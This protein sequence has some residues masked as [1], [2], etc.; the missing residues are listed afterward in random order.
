MIFS[1]EITKSLQ[2][3]LD[4]SHIAKREGAGGKMLDYL[5]TWYVIDL[6]NKIFGFDGWSSETIRL[7]LIGQVM[8]KDKYGKEKFNVG[9]RS[10]VRITIGGVIRDG[11]GFGNGQD[12]SEINA[13]ELALKEA[14]SDALKRAFMKFGNQFGLAL[15]DKKKLNVGVD[16]PEKPN[17][18]VVK[19]NAFVD[20]GIQA[21]EAAVNLTELAEK[22][23]AV[24]A[25]KKY[26]VIKDA[27]PELI[28]TLDDAFT[29]KKD[30]LMEA[31]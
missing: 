13:H 24:Q 30:K 10:T 8:F 1:T 26:K 20:K 3:K 11:S 2:A 21:A 12:V 14:E 9:Y 18:F 4:P 15:Y 6:A 17:E 22:Q 5:E 28:K 31:A 27:L 19:A 16:E 23:V 29:A 7:D 25:A